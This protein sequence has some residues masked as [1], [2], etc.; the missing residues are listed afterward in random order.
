MKI[1]IVSAADDSYFPLLKGLVSSIQDRR[2]DD[3]IAISVL[4]TGLLPQQIEELRSLGVVIAHATWDFEFPPG[5]TMPRSFQAMTAR[6]FLPQ[7]FPDADLYIWLDADVWLQD[8]RA[9]DL[10]IAAAVDGSMAIVPEIHVAYPCTYRLGVV[11]NFEGYDLY[12]KS[13]GAELGRALAE[14]PLFNSGVFALRKDAAAWQTWAKWMDRAMK[15]Q[16]HKLT[17]QNA[18][19]AAIYKDRL[20]V[21]PLPAWCNWVCLQGQPKYELRHGRFVEPTLPHEPISILHVNGPIREAAVTEISVVGGGTVKVP[22]GYLAFKSVRSK[23]SVG[24]ANG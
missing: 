15:N 17:E 11:H 23:L 1:T 22:F 6:C 21:H 12:A 3:R 14:R 18:L 2:P 9:I 20:Q 16:V 5:Q 19:N 10:L 4:D 8:W 7:Y 13:F 24:K